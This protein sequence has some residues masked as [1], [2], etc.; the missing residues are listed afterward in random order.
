MKR[1][2]FSRF[3]AFVMALIIIMCLF[4]C[5][6]N[7][8]TAN[9]DYP[10]MS[11][12]S[13]VDSVY[14]GTEQFRVA[15]TIDGGE[16]KD[17][18]DVE[19]FY[20]TNAFEKVD[21]EIISKS[22]KNVT[23]DVTGEMQKNVAGAYQWGVLGVKSSG[24]IDGHTDI[25]TKIDVVLNYIDFD[26]SSLM[27]DNG[28][29]KGNLK[30]C[31]VADVNQITKNDITIDGVNIENI[32]KVDDTTI[33]ITMALDGANSVNDYVDA[34]TGKKIMVGGYETN[35]NISQATFY[36]VFDK[37]EEAGNNFDITV[38]LYIYGGTIDNSIKTNDIILNEFFADG[39]IKSLK[40][41][42]NNL[43]SLIIS[44]PKGEMNINNYSFSGGITLKAGFI[45]NAWG[46][47]TSKD[48]SYT[49]DYSSETLGKA[50]TLNNDTLLA[51][52]GYTR[53]LNTTFGTIC[54]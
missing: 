39:S 45:T 28:K 30:I 33:N 47:K 38:K 52:Q 6:K 9:T 36:P 12:K 3:L 25:S 22:K 46:E 17:D 21:L 11:L 50:V 16:F 5:S 42:E 35:V 20:R 29:A 41:I 10:K 4:S 7:E 2:M 23:L 53:G 44:V 40:M 15:L 43:G 48:Y 19:D 27:F 51:I 13:D 14:S 24:I 54:Y 8:N 34:I 18:L 32:S 1:I 37:I 49:R 31:G 26:A